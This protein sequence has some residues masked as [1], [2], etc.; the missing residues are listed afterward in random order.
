MKGQQRR[1]NRQQQQ[2]PYEIQ[3]QPQFDTIS[4]T[5]SPQHWNYSS[6]ES[7]PTAV[8]E[9]A[10]SNSSSP[11]WDLQQ[12]QETFSDVWQ[13]S[14]QQQQQL[15]QDQQYPTTAYSDQQQFYYNYNQPCNSNNIS[16]QF[17]S[18][19]EFVPAYN[20]PCNSQFSSPSFPIPDLVPACP[21][22]YFPNDY[23]SNSDYTLN[24]TN[25]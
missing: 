14:L 4:P 5:S 2:S 1:S 25:S 8:E 19:P 12:C 6:V 17:Y 7:S 16:S 20:Q 22:D 15:P 11:I 18:V 23:Y 3:T 10:I 9:P 21:Y 13:N 24:M